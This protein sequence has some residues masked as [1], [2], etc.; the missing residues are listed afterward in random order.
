M[1]GKAV[2]AGSHTQKKS[3]PFKVEWVKLSTRWAETLGGSNGSTYELAIAILFE[4]FKRKH[5]GGD[6]MLSSVVT[7]MPR[8]TKMRAARKLVE[9]GLIRI[10]QKG[11]ERSSFKVYLLP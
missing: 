10:E 8:N 4:A 9:L 11:G 5:V 3:G 6:V 7:G 1:R 2:P